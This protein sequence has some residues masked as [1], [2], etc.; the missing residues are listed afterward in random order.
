M[1][2]K[3]S[4]EVYSSHFLFDL[5]DFYDPNLNDSQGRPGMTGPKG[6]M[7]PKGPK[8]DSGG[9]EGVS[10]KS[11]CQVYAP[12]GDRMLMDHHGCSI[13]SPTETLLQLKG[14][15]GD[16]GQDGR[17]GLPGPPGLPSTGGGDGDSGGVQY[18]P[19]PGPPGPP[20]PPGLPG[21]S[22]SGPKGEPG[23]DSRSSFFGDASYYGRPGEKANE[24]YITNI[25]CIYVTC[26]L[27]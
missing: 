8:G 16:R 2:F 5:A 24:N 22:I 6:E 10:A 13:Y 15:K 4:L 14:D 23:V 25:N 18:I 3:Q 17:D 7:G 19:M 12:W 1:H 11:R 20:G 9:R 27:S 26:E 21:L